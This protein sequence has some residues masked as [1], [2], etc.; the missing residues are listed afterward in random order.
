MKTNLKDRLTDWIALVLLIAQGL[1]NLIENVSNGQPFE[2]KQLVLV[3]LGAFI[4]WVTGKAANLKKK[5]PEQIKKELQLT[6]QKT[7]E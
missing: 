1:Y 4:L 2:W 3:I 6:D 7:T 5:K